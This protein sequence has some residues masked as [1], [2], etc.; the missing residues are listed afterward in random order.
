MN[1]EQPDAGNNQAK[2][3]TISSGKTILILIIKTLKLIVRTKDNA[4][5]DQQPDANKNKTRLKSLQ[6]L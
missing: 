2:M 3:K 6:R 1:V 5:T 4:S